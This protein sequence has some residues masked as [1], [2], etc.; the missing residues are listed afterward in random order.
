MLQVVANRL[1]QTWFL[2]VLAVSSLV[3][4]LGM[5]LHGTAAHLSSV[6]YFPEDNSEWESVSAG[7][8]GWDTV[9]L[10]QAVAFAHQH[11]STS[12]FVLHQGRIVVEEYWDLERPRVLTRLRDVPSSAIAN[13]EGHTIEDVG[14]VQKGVVGGLVGLAQH[15][16]LLQLDASVSGY[17]GTG[18]TRTAAEE[19][20]RIT[21]R[22]LMSMSSGLSR[23]LTY[24]TDPLERWFYNTPAYGRLFDVIRRVSGL[25]PNDYTRA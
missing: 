25:S 5:G 6:T 7:R 23:E 19:E 18:W 21:V 12:L 17:L 4:V 1:R 15:R 2:H 10:N 14:S 16:N 9:A 13:S 8:L 24:E 22:H 11:R 3:L 20:E